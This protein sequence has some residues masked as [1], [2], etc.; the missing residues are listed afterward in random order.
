[1]FADALSSLDRPEHRMKLQELS[2]VERK[3]N[4]RFKTKI[5]IM[6]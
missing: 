3:I 2:A 5:P 4:F 1:M 6:G